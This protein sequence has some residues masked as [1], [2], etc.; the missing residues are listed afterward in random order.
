M[1][2]IDFNLHLNFGQYTFTDLQKG[3][4]N[5]CRTDRFLTI[6]RLS[7]QKDIRQVRTKISRQPS[8]KNFFMLRSIPVYGFCSDNLSAKPSGHRNLLESDATKTL[9]LQNSRKCFSHHSGKGKRESR[10]ANICRL[11]QSLDKQSLRALRRRKVWRSIEKNSLCSGLNDHRFMSFT[12]SMGNISQTQSCGQGTHA[13]GLKRLYTH[14]YPHYRRKSPRCQYS[15]RPDFR[16]GRHLHHGSRLPR[17]RSSL[18]VHSKPFNFYYKSQKQFRLPASLLS[19]S[20]Q[21][22]R[23][24][25]R[26][27]DKTQWLLCLAGLSCGS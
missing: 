21:S 9:S 19:K 20:R 4:A 11:C 3:L 6:V 12:I 17:F 24:S 16:A 10:L 26:P 25:V 2:G 22:N 14:V 7:A 23:P 1:T 5:A 18:Y 27:D 15:R 8:N 13:Y